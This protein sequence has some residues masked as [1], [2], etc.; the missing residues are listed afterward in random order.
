[1][2]AASRG[3]AACKTAFACSGEGEARRY[4]LGL[5]RWEV[6][7]DLGHAT[8]N[9]FEHIGQSDPRARDAALTATHFGKIVV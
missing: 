5:K 8:S 4:V 9:V 3:K 1:M 2:G 6:G 7:Q